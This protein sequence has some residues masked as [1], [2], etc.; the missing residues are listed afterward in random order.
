VSLYSDIGVSAFTFWGG[1]SLEPVMEETLEPE[2]QHP[3]IGKCSAQRD[4]LLFSIRHLPLRPLTP[5]NRVG[6]S[7]N[8]GGSSMLLHG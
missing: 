2:V 5:T 3:A 6:K 8:G 1:A 7:R 4:Y